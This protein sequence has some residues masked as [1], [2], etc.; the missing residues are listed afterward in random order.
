M[1]AAAVPLSDLEPRRKRFTREEVDRMLE[2]GLFAGQRFELLDG[3]LID[4]M[5]QNPPH[6]GMIV[7]IAEWLRSIFGFLRLR[8]QGPIE[9]GDKDR[10]Y[11]EPEPDIAVT[12]LPSDD[13]LV[14][15]PRGDEL[16]LVVE[17]SDSSFRGDVNFKRGLYARA[18]VPEYWVADR[19]RRR[20]LV[21][22]KP[23]DGVY[24]EI[25]TAGEGD[26]VF[27]AAAPEAKAVVRDLFG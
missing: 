3:E 14:R 16:I 7:Y 27:V 10:D 22:R 26:T 21:H 17:V 4:K 6:F 9:V 11:S 1:L 23:V 25:W 13:I 5:G 19:R 8:V 24:T 20:I 2:M 12:A 15:H 18:G